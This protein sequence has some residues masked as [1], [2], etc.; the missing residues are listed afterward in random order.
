MT[1]IAIAGAEGTTVWRRLAAAAIDGVFFVLVASLV[2]VA[3]YTASGGKLR[4][5]VFQPVDRCEPAR[6]ISP[7]VERAALSAVPAQTSRVAS[8]TACRRLF[9]G[10]ESGRFVSVNVEAQQGETLVGAAVLQPVDR[11]GEP[12]APISL[13]WAYPLAFVLCMA[14]GEG[15]MRGT[16]GKA[17]LGLRVAAVGGG[18][19]GL[20]RA[21]GRNLI[22]YGWLLAGAAL[23]A[24]SH[25][26]TRAAP[27][28]VQYARPLWIA[29]LA[30]V[31][32]LAAWALGMLLSGR[33][34]PAYDR[35]MDARVVRT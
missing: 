4:A 13:G 22:V 2:S 25:Q 29:E 24:V 27:W 17:G 11:A 23:L 20:A 30:V 5:Y 26:A 9:L 10:L 21:V 15:L 34:D 18:R 12:V 14:L 32:L 1:G 3:L 31:G 35:W 7:A 33:P 19:L 16:P 8:A 6:E 28:L